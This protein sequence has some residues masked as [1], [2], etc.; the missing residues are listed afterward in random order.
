MGETMLS[1]KNILEFQTR[2]YTIFRSALPDTL[3]GDLRRASERGVK[4]ARERHGP[5]IPFLSKLILGR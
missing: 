4:L 3:L 2:G 5:Q 1:E